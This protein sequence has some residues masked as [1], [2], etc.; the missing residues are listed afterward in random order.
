V[1]LFDA[2]FIVDWSASN[3]PC[4]GKDS[5]WIAQ[6]GA[7]GPELMNP[8]TRQLAS[9]VLVELLRDQVH[10]KRR[11]LIAFDFPYG[12]PTGFAEAVGLGGPAPP[13]RRVWQ[14]LQREMVDDGRNHNNRFQVAARLNAR[15]GASPGPFWGSPKGTP[16]VPQK[17]PTF[18]YVVDGRQSLAEYRQ[19]EAQMRQ[20][21]GWVHSVWQLWTAGNVGGQA[22]TGIP[23]LTALRDHLDLAPHSRVWPFETGFSRQPTDAKHCLLVHA[24]IWPGAIPIDWSLHPVKDAAQVLSLAHHFASLDTR[25]E[26]GQLFQ[27]PDSVTSSTLRQCTE[28]EGWIVGL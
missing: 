11:A 15:L 10:R 13:W 28:T 4:R 6:Q 9:E 22:L 14:M 24:E 25:G 2:Y 27:G 7:P 3:S 20:R 16:G 5:V 19:A 26:L 23:R 8:A 1:S 21:K 17:K 18:P 12:Y